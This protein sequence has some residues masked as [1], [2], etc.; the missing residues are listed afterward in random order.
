MAPE[1][2]VEMIFGQFVYLGPWI[3]VPLV[4]A[5]F[6]PGWRGLRDERRL[7][8]ICLALPPIVVFTITP[9]WGARGLPHWPM[10]GWFF[11]FPLL[12]AWL[13]EP[14][15][16]RFGVK[17]WTVGLSALTGLLAILVV[18]QA[19]TGWATRL[20]PLPH[21]TVDPTLEMLDWGA[22][23]RGAAHS[24]HPA[25]VVTTRWTEAGKIGLA[26]GPNSP[27]S[28]SPAIPRHS[29]SRHG[30]RYVG[31]DGV[32]VVPE[33]RLNETFTKLAL[34]RALR[35]AADRD[36]APRRRRRDRAGA[37]SQPTA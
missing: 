5:L 27:F 34:L 29:V 14:W 26:L 32:V 13:C 7:F 10:P 19:A 36:A 17:R 16:Q 2:V 33:R 21:G 20:F 11:A 25:F 22:L 30:S 24:G 4:G 12:G 9:L 1:Q 23:P 6:A 37:R 15:A 31:Q 35:P 3:F 18:S 28:P 8:L